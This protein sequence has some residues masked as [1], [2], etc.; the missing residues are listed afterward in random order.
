MRANRISA[1]RGLA[2]LAVLLLAALA[3]SPLAADPTATPGPATLY[4]DDFS[5]S[6]SGWGV[7][8][9]ETGSL[10][11]EAGQ[12][13]FNMTQSKYMTWG[14]LADETFTDV[15]VV[16]EVE[17]KSNTTEPTFGVICNYQDE[18]NFYYAG[19]GSDGFYAIVLSQNGNDTILTDLSEGNWLQS[20]DI[21]VE[22]DRYEVAVEC[23]RG[24]IKLV[25]DGK[26]I[27][28]VQDDTFTTGQIGLFVLTWDEPTADVRFDNL[29]VLE[30]E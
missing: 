20:D 19:F 7:G 27:A 9:D 12:Y 13:R 25:V 17:N 21:A 28:T 10:Q 6:E 23:A 18:N 2:P 1:W 15:R 3:C 11:Y 5:N 24:E 4:K 26:T 16:T 30:A 22:A 29:R 8:T 14:N